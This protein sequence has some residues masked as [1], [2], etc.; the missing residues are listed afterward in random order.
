MDITWNTGTTSRFPALWLRVLGPSKAL[1]EGGC[2]PR[3]PS[4]VGKD[5]RSGVECLTQGEKR[6]RDQYR[7]GLIDIM[8][9]F[10]EEDWLLDV[11]TSLL[12]EMVEYVEVELQRESLAAGTLAAK[13]SR[14]D[15]TAE[16]SDDG[17]LIDEDVAE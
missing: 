11:P 13:E 3:L 6:V 12:R 8:I 16:S 5:P 10:M 1:E 4:P 14:D 17:T 9:E 2:R 7:V 15:A